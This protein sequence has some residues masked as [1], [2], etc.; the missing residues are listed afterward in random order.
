MKYLKIFLIVL[1]FTVT[2]VFI[3]SGQV[4]SQTNTMA[5]TPVP[6]S[7]GNPSISGEFL[8]GNTTYTLGKGDIVQI[9]VREQE[10]FSGQFVIGPDGN[11]QYTFVGD[12]KAEG[13]DK[14]QLKEEITKKLE[15]FIKI[16]EVSVIIAAYRSKFIYILGE[17]GRP[18]KYPMS[19]DAIKLR[20]AIVASGLP[21]RDAALRRVWVIKP[22]YTKKA[23]AKKV[24]IYKLLYKG[25]LKQDVVLKPGDLVVVSSTVPSEI[26]RALTNLL[27]PITRAAVV[28]ELLDTY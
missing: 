24:D 20:D 3:N 9:S 4:Y 25:D 13:L 15:K 27:S 8:E 16:P 23:E 14:N 10:E 19:G 28:E 22:G 11:I 17:V 2:L 1:L 18:G 5:V 21:T 26:N 6:S 7:Q 12:V